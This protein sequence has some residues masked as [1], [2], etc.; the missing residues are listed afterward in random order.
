MPKA[1]PT[2]GKTLLAPADHTLLLI[3]LQPQMAFATRSID[4]AALR[5]NAAIIAEAAAGFDV[6][7]ILTTVAEKTFSGPI[8]EEIKTAFPRSDILDRTTINAWEDE[9]I[10]D[11]INRLGKPKI[12]AA[13]LWTSICIAEPVLSALDQGFDVYVI[14]DAC[15]DISCEA[16]DYG[17]QRMIQAGARPLTSLQYLLELQRDWSRSETYELTAGIARRLGGAYGLGILYAERMLGKR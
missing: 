6:P 7:A 9:R 5:N 12:V 8:F 13:G 16:H 17:L 1:T 3:D 15:G 2:A 11:R 10:T 4:A 14:A